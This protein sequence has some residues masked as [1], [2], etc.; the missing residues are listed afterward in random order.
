MDTTTE[1]STNS[2]L[3]S[4]YVAVTMAGFRILL[5]QSEIHSLE[6]AVDLNREEPPVLGVGWISFDGRDRPVY[7]LGPDLTPS[8]DLP[9]TRR[10]CLL[11]SASEGYFGLMC[12]ELKI[13][14]A[15][16]LR[17]LPLPAI[18]RS[19][20]TPVQSLALYEGAPGAVVTADRLLGFLDFCA[21]I[22]DAHGHSDFPH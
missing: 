2:T 5:A 12:D 4:L 19:P 16:S 13:L 15:T 14:S 9:S 11:L 1:T 21:G 6:P 18:M 10:I 7:C 22:V 17:P 20:H 8:E 3:V